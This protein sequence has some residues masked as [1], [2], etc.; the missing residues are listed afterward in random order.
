MEQRFTLKC[1]RTAIIESKEPA[2]HHNGEE[3]C[4]RHAS[5]WA[6]AGLRFDLIN[7]ESVREL[8]AAIDNEAARTKDLGPP[9]LHIEAHGTRRE[10]KPQM[11]A[12][13]SGL[14]CAPR[15]RNSTMRPEAISWCSLG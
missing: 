6:T 1:S 5:T 11:E 3:I 2:D 10:S 9:I 4:R 8:L 15:F 14:I 13:A 12:Y 7:V